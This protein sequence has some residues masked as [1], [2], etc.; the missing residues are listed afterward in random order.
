[1]HLVLLLNKYVTVS[2]SLIFTLQSQHKP[3]LFCCELALKL[4]QFAFALLYN[5]SK[6][7]AFLLELFEELV[8]L[9]QLVL[10]TVTFDLQAA[11][12]GLALIVL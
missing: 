8:L 4:V 6:L 5:L 10:L 11:G 1:M 2:G 12:Q 9:I 7:V 3:F